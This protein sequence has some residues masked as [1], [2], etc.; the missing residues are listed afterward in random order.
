MTRTAVF[1][2]GSLVNA[3]SAALTLG[4][5]VPSPV[6]A[7]LSGWRRRWTVVR[8]NL[9]VEKKFAIEPGGEIPRWILGLSLEPAMAG[10]DDADGAPNGA[11]LEL[12][13]AELDRLD[14][15]EMRYDRVD[16][17]A[18]IDVAAGFDRVIAYRAKAAHQAPTPPPGAVIL[19]P[20]LR[21]VEEAFEALGDGQ[22]ELFRQTTRPPPVSLVEAVLIED[23]I[24]FGNPR[25]W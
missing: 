2:Y 24:P 11:L 22:L 8:D 10:D 5:D 16:V 21:A 20:Y 1:G 12:T 4:R 19:A 3:S 23:R 25:A 7:R 14:L 17:T 13:G 6:P 9:A 18:G 15:R